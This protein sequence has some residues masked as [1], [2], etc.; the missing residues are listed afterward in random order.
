M[1]VYF[2]YTQLRF[3]LLLGLKQCPAIQFIPMFS[4][5]AS[6]SE[7]LWFLQSRGPT[8]WILKKSAGLGM[9]HLQTDIHSEGSGHARFQNLGPRT[10]GPYCSDPIPHFDPIRSS[11]EQRPLWHK[12]APSRTELSETP[13]KIWITAASTHIRSKSFSIFYNN[14]NNHIN[15]ILLL[16]IY[17]LLSFL[18]QN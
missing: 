3:L 4:P 14:N 13:P 7:H 8:P 16:C 18:P 6:S 9:F 12:L 11:N 2:T 1:L 5:W 10:S 15:H 17:L